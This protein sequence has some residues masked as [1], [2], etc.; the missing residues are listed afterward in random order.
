MSFLKA[1][2]RKLVMI[3]YEVNPKILEKYLP[4]GT[5]LDFFQN[6]CYASVVGFMFKNTKLLGVKIPFH[7]NFEEVNLRFYVKRK[8][9]EGYKRGVVFIKEIV[10]KS[11]ITFV[12]NTFYNENY[13]TLP[14]I[15][16]WEDKEGSLKVTY[17]WKKNKKWNYIKVEAE[18]SLNKIEENSVIEF[19]SEHYWGYAKEDDKSTTEYEVK[20]SKWEYY[21]IN[22]YTVSIDFESNYG[23][24]FSFLNDEKPTSVMLLEGSEISVE[25]KKSIK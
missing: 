8:T 22:T 4:V 7:I 24:D 5:E 6:K 13:E 3:N 21:K 2:W 9:K 23:S 1:E 20:H 12:A 16:S 14:M 10:P 15:H 18:N 25:N 11:A 19:I 17:Q